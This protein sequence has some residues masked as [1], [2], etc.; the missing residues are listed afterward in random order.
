MI[1]EWWECVFEDGHDRM[2]PWSWVAFSG[3]GVLLLDVWADLDGFKLPSSTSAAVGAIGGFDLALAWLL[4]GICSDGEEICGSE[5]FNADKKSLEC[6]G[7]GV[8]S[9]MCGLDSIDTWEVGGR[10]RCT[11][12]GALK[13]LGWPRDSRTRP[14]VYGMS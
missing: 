11:G 6:V 13:G 7:A 14:P 5:K 9:G 4:L 1:V 3:S 8:F 12:I 2:D 10:G